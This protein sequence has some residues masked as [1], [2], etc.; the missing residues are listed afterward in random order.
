MLRNNIYADTGVARK[1]IEILSHT[2]GNENSKTSIL[3]Q[4]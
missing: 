2:G 3:I 1:R 4:H